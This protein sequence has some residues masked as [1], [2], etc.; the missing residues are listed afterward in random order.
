MSGIAAGRSGLAAG[1]GAA[2]GL[3]TAARL[4]GIGVPAAAAL[5]AAAVAVDV[6]RPFQVA[7]VS[8]D[9][10]S[11]VAFFDRIASGRRLEAFVT[12]TPKPL[13]TVLYG[14]VHG[15]SH[16]WRPI[17]WLAILSFALAVAAA[18]SLALRTG[19][20]VAGAFAGV[21]LAGAPTLLGD[22][23][24]AGG[25][26]WAVAGW[27]GAG[28]LLTSSRP[29][30]ATAGLALLIAALARV[31][32]F[33]VLGVATVG[34]A[35]LA[36]G[37]LPASLR[38]PPRRAFAILIGFGALPCM[39]LHDWLLTGDPFFW[40]TVSV[41]FS[42]AA[43]AAVMTPV[44]VVSFLV[45]RYEPA[46]PLVLLGLIGAVDLL[47]RRRWVVA[48]GLLAVGPGIAAF[49]VLLAARGIYVS[50]RYAEPIDVALR[51]VAAF[52]AAALVRG[53]FR[54]AD[55]TAGRLAIP[56][57]P[58]VRAVRAHP[59]GPAVAALAVGAAAAV[60][61]G[62]PFGPRDAVLRRDVAAE[63][64][65]NGNEQAVLPVLAAAVE[66][67][68][69]A[70][71]RAA[72]PGSA[73]AAVPR[74]IVPVL[75]RPRVAVDLG[76]PLW[77]VGSRSPAADGPNAAQ[78]SVPTI[79]YHDAGADRPVAA[80]RPFEIDRPGRLGR[81]EISPILASPDRGL[82]VVELTPLTP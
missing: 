34:L 6:V 43:P 18:A 57:A 5:L 69:P 16:D 25:V 8:F 76:L 14:I 80:Y 56:G 9:A 59:A 41:V 70:R 53:L 48:A 72:A 50:D 7:P 40:M 30:Y 1:G 36:F 75:L 82:W 33:V 4:L 39:L 64:A 17:S 2:R 28:L 66:R 32:T 3:S 20:P 26:A 67:T 61:A 54:A 37:P 55:R 11:S 78:V 22:V 51:F 15:L 47:A 31:E 27:V 42:R 35:W 81:L 74:L 60:L 44:Q 46:W 49:L 73:A 58:T 68:F 38:R 71:E 23:S 45:H 63:R 24:L 62:G 29:R 52:G 77:A 19:G 65:L 21:A 79:V 12:T 13:L 10:A